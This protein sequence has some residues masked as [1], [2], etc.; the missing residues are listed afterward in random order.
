MA[1]EESDD[2]IIGK[3]VEFLKATPLP[4]SIVSSSGEIFFLNQQMMDIV[5]LNE[6]SPLYKCSWLIDNEDG[7]CPDCAEAP[8]ME[9]RCFITR[10]NSDVTLLTAIRVRQA[11]NA[12][13][14]LYSNGASLSPNEAEMHSNRL[15][16]IA[17]PDI[18]DDKADGPVDFDSDW[19]CG[20]SLW[21][22]VQNVIDSHSNQ[23]ARIENLVEKNLRVKATNPMLIGRAISK[24]L[25][26]LYAMKS[27][28]PV[29][30]KNLK[31]ETPPGLSSYHVINFTV[32]SAKAQGKGRASEL[33]A[34]GLRLKL[35]Y[36]RM[37]QATGY[38]FPEPSLSQRDG[39]L[40]IQ[41]RVP[42]VLEFTDDLFSGFS[43]GPSSVLSPRE[44][45]IV[46]MVR[47]G[48]NNNAIASSLGITHA[49]VKQHL[50]A[51][52]RKLD[53]TNRIDLIFR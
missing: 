13:V 49:T 34:I 28:A 26:E 14:R 1:K 23:P 43:D 4:A 46:E 6:K 33:T 22:I 47:S 25:F 19:L 2:S 20:A 42:D 41:L 38:H 12:L 18:K 48:Y 5:N 36:H 11:H 53:V 44:Q 50:K 8:V 29:T 39:L 31:P 27:N 51:I 9:G 10:E 30:I 45:E 37:I 3:V 15:L 16:K 40:T 32:K 7:S 35:F 21:R 24:I 17:S 52:Y